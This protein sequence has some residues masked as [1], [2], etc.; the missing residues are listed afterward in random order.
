MCDAVFGAVLVSSSKLSKC[1]A[2]AEQWNRIQ[3]V[4][5]AV[6]DADLV[7]NLTQQDL[8]LY[9]TTEI[10]KVPLI[11]AVVTEKGIQAGLS[12]RSLWLSL[13]CEVEV[14]HQAQFIT[15]LLAFA[16]S[17]TKTRVVLGGDDF[18]FVSGVPLHTASGRHLAEA[19]VKS[20]FEGGRVVDYVGSLKS[21]AVRTYIDEG[22]AIAAKNNW[23]FPIVAT[24]QQSNEMFEF[25]KRAFPGRWAREF[26][27]WRQRED[28]RRAYWHA[29]KN[30]DGVAIGFARMAI[31]GRINNL[32][33]GWS[34]GALRLS[35][36]D[37]L[38]MN[39]SCLGPIGVAVEHR[40]HGAGRALLALV[41]DSLFIHNAGRICIDWTNA[42]KYYYPLNFEEQRHYW[43]GAK[44][45][46]P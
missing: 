9:E 41:L 27:F 7:W 21:P 34:P 42:F 38:L 17:K 1:R 19:L 30:S 14:L 15:E 35:L 36:G 40:G 25:L 45:E 3:G 39:D 18:H 24:T 29:L 28:A 44:S 43:A 4:D 23:S 31:R 5:Y 20:G 37:G 2:I 46:V 22:R 12:A 11:Y 33:Q 26:E 16:K 32:D 8:V 6:R 13:W 10:C